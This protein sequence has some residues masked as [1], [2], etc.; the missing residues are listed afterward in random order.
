MLIRSFNVH[1][2]G[3][4]IKKSNIR[5]LIISK[6]L[7][8]LAIQETKLSKVSISLV[9]SL[10]GNPSGTGVFPRLLVIVV[11]LFLFRATQKCFTYSPLWVLGTLGFL[12]E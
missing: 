7:E 10:W 9:P 6:S 5:D 1:G 12:L 11:A 2:L 3:S 4:Q 8:F